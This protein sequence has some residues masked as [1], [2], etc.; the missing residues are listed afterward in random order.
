VVLF[1]DLVGSTELEFRLSRSDADALRHA[2]FSSLREAIASSGGTEV[3]STGDGLMVVFPSASAALDC[4]V[5]MQQAIEHHNRRALQP[6]SVRVGMSSGDLT[7]ATNEYFGDS[8]VEAARLCAAAGGG[9]ILVADVVKTLASRSGHE[10]ITRQELDLKGI[11]NRVVA[12][13][14]EI[15]SVA[16]VGVAVIE[17]HPVFRQGL[18]QT[19]ESTPGLD[20]VA[21][22]GTLAD[23]EDVGYAGVQVVVLDLH[24]P[25]GSGVEAVSRVK[26]HGPAVL[27]VSASDDRQSVVDAIAAGASGYLPKSAAAEEIAK[28]ASLVAGGGSY[29]SPVLAAFLLGANRDDQPGPTALTK[30][31]REILALLAEGETDFEIAERLFIS[32]STVRSHLDRIRDKTGRRRRADLTRL[33]LEERKRRP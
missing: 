9:H 15:P 6:L 29:V 3:K 26:A 14:L 21:S 23:M 25:D 18:M 33:A 10:F 5:A 13:E 27:V 8:A 12:W 11:P 7:V 1:T 17:D 4:A 22:V 31:E 30:R 32:I 2:H 20:L 24:L 16:T 28:A 19:I